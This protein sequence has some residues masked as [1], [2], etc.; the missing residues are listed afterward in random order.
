[1]SKKQRDQLYLEVIKHQQQAPIEMAQNDYMG[2]IHP[3]GH[4]MGHPMGH[5]QIPPPEYLQGYN[6]QHPMP[7]PRQFQGHP[8]HPPPV[9]GHQMN[10]IKVEAA[11]YQPPYSPPTNSETASNGKFFYFFQIFEFFFFSFLFNFHMIFHFFFDNSLF[12]LKNSDIL[13]IWAPVFFNG[14]KK[15]I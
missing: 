1:M 13:L 12:P 11:P 15:I 6:G 9:Q 8:S 3:Y 10:D 2:H 7:V 14:F 5:G 4:P